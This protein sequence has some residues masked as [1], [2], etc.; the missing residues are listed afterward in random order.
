MCG[1]AG[2]FGR[3]DRADLERM[4]NALAHRGPDG[5]GY[6]VEVDTPVFLGH[7]RL[8]IVDVASGHQPMWNEDGQVGV[9][10]NGEIYNHLELRAE[11]IRRGHRFASDHSDT[12]VLVHG[13]EEWGVDLPGRLNGMFA[14]AIYDR[15]QGCLFLARDRFGEKPLYYTARNGLFA[16]ASEARALTAHPG[17]GHTFDRRALQKL[18]A[19]GYIPSPCAVYEGMHKLPG[20][21]WLRFDLASERVETR[22]YWHFVLEP[23]DGLT[24]ADEPRLVDELTGLLIQGARR[25]LMSDVPLGVFLSGGLDSSVVLAALAS[26]QPGSNFDTFTIG[27]VEPSFDESAHARAVAEHIGSRH[28]ERRLDM[29]KA[30]DLIPSVLS[31]L[32]EPLGDAS[33]LPTAMLSAFARE[34]VTVALSGDGGDE[35]FA[36]Y[37]P[38]LA[39]GP[40]AAYDKVVPGWG[41]RG[42]RRLADLLPISHDNMSLDFKIRRSLM[43]L[44]YPDNVRL[45]VWMS[46]LEPSEFREFC[47]EPV[48]YED[49]YSEAIELWETGSG[50][51][52]VDRSL[53]FFTRYYLQDDILMKVD[54]AAMM[55]SLETRAVF[56]DN[57]IVDFCR[58]LPN[59][60][61]LRGGE[62]KYLLK[63]VARRLLP[64]SIVD[65]KKKGFGIPLA[66]WLKEVPKEPPLAPVPGL[67]L[68]FVRDAWS[69]H[70]SG[71]TDRRLFLWTWLSLQSQLGR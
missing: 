14:L 43:G 50:T 28:H 64:K 32:D 26:E 31:A 71:R 35:L 39:L 59:R 5:S 38:F 62:R 20:G 56:L 44:S 22:A 34:N 33:I 1:L 65:R 69:G 63:Q 8:A 17:V 42:L 46:P 66:R 67:N 24:D 15:R 48:R 68:D 29:H 70:R 58:R 36:G 47:E 61:K 6:H 10:F 51:N 23:D 40:A 16:F 30:R 53:E 13:W 18:F 54:R 2:F 9:V 57:D 7:R 12:E 11:L 41:H 25:R 60:F 45:P 49:V 55:H 3:G 52:P 21:H 19:Y 27:F 37:D 4:T